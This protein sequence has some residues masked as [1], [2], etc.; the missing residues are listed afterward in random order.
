MN[1]DNLKKIVGLRHEL[2]AHPEL[3]SREEWTKNRLMEFL[4]RHTD[5]EIVDKGAWF[6]AFYHAGAGRRTIAFRADMD[7]VPIDEVIELTYGSRFPGVSHKCGHDGHCA[8]LCGFA[9]EVSQNGAGC[10]IYFLFQHAEETAEGAVA[11]APLMKEKG[12][13]E[14]FCCH[15]MPGY[16]LNSVAVIDGTICCASKGMIISLIGTPAHASLPESGK[17]PSFA[18][19]ALINSIPGLIAPEKYQGLVLCTIIQ[20]SI[21]E[22]AFG[23][24]AS[25]GALLLTIRGQYESEMNALQVQLEN[26]TQAE[27]D[28]YGLGYSF[29][30]CDIFPE[31]RNHKES[32]DK[33]RASCQKLGLR[34]VEMKEPL[35]SSEDFGYFTKEIK[36]AAFF[37]G[38]GAEYP[39]IHTAEYDFPDE[40]LETPIEMFK[41]L[42]G[43]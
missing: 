8:A 25:A 5:L 2:H 18:I 40:T 35:R 37:V 3:S 31:T 1:N 27:A 11:C 42:S 38:N 16:P 36:G 15:N 22:R 10:N 29:D 43:L 7:A 30:F 34:L 20:V 17:N 39:P 12:I 14:I 6:Y 21:G 13:D 32:S 24:S 33:V 4:K 41:A 23:V 28:K 19:A 26:I 9:M